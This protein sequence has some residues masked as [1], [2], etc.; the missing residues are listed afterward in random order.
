MMELIMK[1]KN[2]LETYNLECV[3]IWTYVIYLWYDDD[4]N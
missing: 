2:H 1:K 4:D 3:C